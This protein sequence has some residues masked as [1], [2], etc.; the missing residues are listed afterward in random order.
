MVGYVNVIDGDLALED[1]GE[2]Y[3]EYNRGLVR[4]HLDCLFCF[5][6]YCEVLIT[7]QD[8]GSWGIDTPTFLQYRDGRSCKLQRR[9]TFLSS[10]DQSLERAVSITELEYKAQ[11]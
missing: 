11:P 8:W 5:A 9:E 3:R 7:D 2:E 4:V 6:F 10:P 1:Q